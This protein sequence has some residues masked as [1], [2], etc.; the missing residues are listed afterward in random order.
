MKRYLG[1]IKRYFGFLP[2]QKITKIKNHN[3]N[4]KYHHGRIKSDLDN[5]QKSEPHKKLSWLQNVSSGHINSSRQHRKVILV[6]SLPH[7][8]I[9]G[10]Q[11]VISEKVILTT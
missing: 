7:T 9:M 3:N 2:P 4:I 6:T 1:P 11:N 10:T 8:K 5:I